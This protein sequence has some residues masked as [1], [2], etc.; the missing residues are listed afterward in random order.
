MT[1]EDCTVGVVGAVGA[2]GAVGWHDCFAEVGDGIPFPLAPHHSLYQCRTR[3]VTVVD[4]IPEDTA[5]LSPCRAFHDRM[6][7]RILWAV[8]TVMTPGRF[9]PPN[10]KQEPTETPMSGKHLRQAVDEDAVALL[11]PLLYEGTYRCNDSEPSPRLRQSLLP[12]RHEIAPELGRRRGPWTPEFGPPRLGRSRLSAAPVRGPKPNPVEHRA[13]SFAGS[14]RPG[15]RVKAIE[16]G[17]RCSNAV[18][19]VVVN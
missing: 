14:T 18:E 10:Q 1:I 19:G 17:G 15:D 12:F 8:L 16:C 9:L 4:H 6:L 7:H 3:E 2:V 5:V 11:K 13:T